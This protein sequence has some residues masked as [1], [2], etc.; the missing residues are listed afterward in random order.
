M[1]LLTGIVI[2]AHAQEGFGT[3]TPDASAVIDMTATNKGVLLPRVAL[4][5]TNA[6]GPISSPASNL[7]VYNIATAGIS[8]N[9][10]TPGFYY[11]NGTTWIRLFYQTDD[12]GQWN[13]TGNTGTTPG[14]IF[15]GTTDVQDLVFKTNATERM[16]I[17]ATGNVGVGTSTPA[18]Q[19]D[20]SS[21]T[22]GFLPPRMTETQ[23][24]A[25]VSPLDGLMVYNTTKGCL[26]YY[27]GGGF[28]CIQNKPSV[29][30]SSLTNFYNGWV[31]GSF[32]GT[33]TTVT[34]AS[35]EAFST[36]ATCA[37][38]GI[39]VTGCGGVTT[40]AGTTGNTYA[41]TEINGQC[42][43]AENMREIPSAYSG[44]TATS[45][46]AEL[47]GDAGYW[48]YYNTSTSDG[49]A[50]WGTMEPSNVNGHEGLLYQWSAAMNGVLTERSRGICP[51]GFHVPSDCEFMYLEHGLGMKVS[52]QTL[53]A[54]LRGSGTEVISSKLTKDNGYNNASGFSALFAGI[55]SWDGT[56][57]DHQIKGFWWSSSVVD[58]STSFLRYIASNVG[59]RGVMR[60]ASLR[61]SSLSV[62]CLKD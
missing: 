45:W 41:L 61:S 21:I 60:A 12:L 32:T 8:P 57:N 3:N 18:A 1:L 43:T 10:V 62:R 44:Y 36:N 40:V 17:T 23:M 30:G 51:S 59:T 28:N 19:M 6:A 4:T 58:A 42:W 20:L 53:N 14:T 46:L 7:L 25:I 22:Q 56:L 24:A 52:Y 9:N 34:H 13:S 33:A 11:W 2:T 48:G 26:A 29:L 15:V 49:S 31:A 50:G 27:S 54:Q 35:G 47:P 37:S 38:K 39:S 55:R 16:R 5:A